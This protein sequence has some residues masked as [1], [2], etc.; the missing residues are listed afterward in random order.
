M[1]KVLVIGDSCRDIFIYGEIDRI[2]PEAPVPVIKP[3]NRTENGGMAKNVVNNLE[4]L[5]VDT[6]NIITNFSE[7]K[8]IRYVDFKSNQLVLRVDEDDRCEKVN[9]NILMFIS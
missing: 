1:S 7:I 4:A 9:K 3:V 8:K 5:G 2:C 6:V